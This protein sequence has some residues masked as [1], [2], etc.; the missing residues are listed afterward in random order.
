MRSST[1]LSYMP[2]KLERGNYAKLV[3]EFQEASSGQRFRQCV[4]YLIT[5]VD[6]SDFESSAL[7]LVPYKVIVDGDMFHA[8]VKHWVDTEECSSNVFTEY[9]R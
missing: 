8:R 4:C 7:N 3:S 1:Y 2:L 6:V 9:D 5:S